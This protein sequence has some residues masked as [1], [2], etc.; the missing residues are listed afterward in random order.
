MNHRDHSTNLNGTLAKVEALLH[1]G[2]ELPNATALLAK[3]GLR[4]SRQNDDLRLVG[5]HSHLNTGIAVLGQ[6]AAQKLVQFRL[7]N[8][9]GD[10]LSLLGNGCSHVEK[11]STRKN[12]SKRF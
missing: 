4:P 6:L 11:K 7:E 9:I 3:H 10:E 2:G 1:D 12:G 8:A 5:R